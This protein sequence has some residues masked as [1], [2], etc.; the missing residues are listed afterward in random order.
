MSVKARSIKSSS[1][2][3]YGLFCLLFH[4]FSIY[5][6]ILYQQI[7]GWVFLGRTSVLFVLFTIILKIYQDLLSI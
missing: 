4:L 6:K 1:L 3:Y 7:W 5:K 2:V